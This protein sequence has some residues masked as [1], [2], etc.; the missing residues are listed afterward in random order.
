MTAAALTSSTVGGGG[1]QDERGSRQGTS[2]VGP[3][4]QKARRAGR[5]G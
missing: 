5:A 2:F 4:L 3:P 1:G